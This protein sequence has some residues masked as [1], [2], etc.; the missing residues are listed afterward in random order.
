MSDDARWISVG[1]LAQAFALDNNTPRSTEDLPVHL[2]LHLENGQVV[3][4]EFSPAQSSSGGCWKGSG[5]RAGSQED[6]RGQQ[7][8]RDGIYSWTSEDLERPPP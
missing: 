1:E 2:R 7:G 4:H 8:C 5:R 6:L 3:E